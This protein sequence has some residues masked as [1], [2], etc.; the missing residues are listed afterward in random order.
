ME[1]QP[2]T[3]IMAGGKGFFERLLRSTKILLRKEVG[4][5]KLNYEQLQTVLL[6]N[7]TI[8]NNRPLTY[9]YAD[10]NKPCLTPIH[11]LYGQALKLC[12]PEINSDV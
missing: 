11:M 4:N 5:L 10:E 9:Y 7:E 8:L 1:V 6:E 2:T 3:L 12:D